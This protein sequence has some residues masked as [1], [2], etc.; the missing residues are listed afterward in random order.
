MEAMSPA[1]RA[2]VRVPVDLFNVQVGIYGTYHLTASPQHAKTFF[3]REILWD[4]PTFQTGPG[5]TATPVPPS[6]VRLRRPATTSR[7]CHPTVRSP[8]AP[9]DTPEVEL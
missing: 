3:A 1:M 2:H 7:Q 9:M 8:P 4:L 6:T 5:S